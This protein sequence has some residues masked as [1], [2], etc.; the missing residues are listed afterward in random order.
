MF[1]TNNANIFKNVIETGANGFEKMMEIIDKH[2]HLTYDCYKNNLDSIIN[3][4]TEVGV[5]NIINI[6]CNVKNAIEARDLANKYDHIYFSV[7]V[8]PCDISNDIDWGLF[9]E[10]LSH[11]KCKAVGECGF[12]LYHDSTTLDLQKDVFIKQI[13][14][15]KKYN[16]PLVI[17]T[18]DAGIHTL[19]YLI[20]NNVDNFVIHCF[21]ESQSFADSIISIGGMASF[22]GIITYKNADGI[23]NVLKS[24]PLDRIMLETDC[25][26]LAPQSIRGKTNSPV[27][28]PEIA[29]KMSEVLNMSIDDIAKYTTINAKKFFVL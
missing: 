7:G 1:F 21:S 25:P 12:D 17:H 5:K 14:L 11:A 26:F 3:D 8:H 27:H 19:D 15:S 22:G 20:N 28:I 16:L 23:R 10:L 29:C 2:S 13:D 6:S 4:A 24:F 9:E 18:R